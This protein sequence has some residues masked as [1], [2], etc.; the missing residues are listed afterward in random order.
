MCRIV[1][2]AAPAVLLV[3]APCPA[4][5]FQHYRAVGLTHEVERSA[6]HALSQQTFHLVECSYIAVVIAH[7]VHQSLSL[8][9]LHHFLTLFHGQSKRLLTEHVASM[10]QC[11][12]HHL[13]VQFRRCHHIHAVRFHLLYHLLVV[14]VALNPCQFLESTLQQ[15]VRITDRHQF[16]VGESTKDGSMAHTHLPQSDNHSFNHFQLLLCLF[17]L[18]LNA[19]VFLPNFLMFSKSNARCRKNLIWLPMFLRN[20]SGL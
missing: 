1:L 8:R 3:R 18:V 13:V 6:Y 10:F 15:T 14:G 5:A 4:L 12:H 2:Y 11:K 7:L 19:G 17:Y 16:H 9:H 20:I